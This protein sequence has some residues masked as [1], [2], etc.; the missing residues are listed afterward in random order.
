MIE[1]KDGLAPNTDLV[2]NLCGVKITHICMLSPDWSAKVQ[3]EGS[4][5]SLRNHLKEKHG[6]EPPKY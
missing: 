4:L 5:S 2:C 1:T 6:I 3:F